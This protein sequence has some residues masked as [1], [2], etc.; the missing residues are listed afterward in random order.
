MQDFLK[1]VCWVHVLG[2]N[3]NVLRQAYFVSGIVTRSLAAEFE[4]MGQSKETEHDMHN[5]P[6]TILRIEYEY[7]VIAFESD[8]HL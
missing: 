7:N 2:K 5:K 8:V 3:T 4:Q 1:F 6:F